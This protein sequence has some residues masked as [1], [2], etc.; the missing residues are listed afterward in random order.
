MEEAWSFLFVRHGETESNRDG[1][2]AGSSDVAL[3]ADG[4]NQAAIA[5]SALADERIDWIHTSPLRR[6]RDTAAVIGRASGRPVEVIR[7]LA[8]RNWG[9]LEGARLPVD[10]TQA[11]APGGETLDEFNARVARGIGLCRTIAAGRSLLVVSHAGVF[12]SLCDLYRIPAGSDWVANAQ[13]IRFQVRR[14]GE[15]T[16]TGIR[17]APNRAG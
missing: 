8:E 1:W 15:A 2:L 3:T 12:R 6:A 9:A 14:D 17:P 10:L 13:P 5:A 7:D 11:A 16:V 4:L